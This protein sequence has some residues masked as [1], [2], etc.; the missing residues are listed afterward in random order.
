MYLGPSFQLEERFARIIAFFFIALSYSAAMPTMYIIGCF[1]CFLI[2]WSDKILF[3]RFYKKPPLFNVSLALSLL[4]T[5]EYALLFHVFFGLMM[6][7]NPNIYANST[8]DNSNPTAN[9]KT[10]S[11]EE[12]TFL[13]QLNE[14]FH[15][16]PH[17]VDYV[18]SST[19]GFTPNRFDATYSFIYFWFAVIFFVL[20]FVENWFSWLSKFV[21][22]PC[23]R[24]LREDIEDPPHISTNIY[25]HLGIEDLHSQYLVT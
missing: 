24:C 16:F 22:E 23:E 5:I 19:F 10:G 3:L 2:Y 9:K 25:Q 15:L 1:F 17:D 7:T 18:T 20:F 13:E 14:F 21:V 11:S 12:L 4:K 6:L 8:T